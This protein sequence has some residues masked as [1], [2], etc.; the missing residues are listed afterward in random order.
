MVR[1]LG[2]G[3]RVA[4][5]VVDAT[6]AFRSTSSTRQ[7]RPDEAGAAGDEDPFSFEHD[8]ESR[9]ST[10]RAAPWIPGKDPWTEAE[11]APVGFGGARARAGCATRLAP[12]AEPLARAQRAFNDAMLRLTDAL[13]ERVDEPARVPGGRERRGRSSRSGCCGSSVAA[14]KR[15]DG[16]WRL[17]RGRTR[18]RLLR[19]RVAD[20]RA[21][22]RGRASGSGPTWRCSREH[23]P[24]LDVGCG[25]GELLVLLREAGIAARGVD[26]DGDMVAFARGE[27][28]TVEQADALDCTGS[29]GR[30]GRSG[31]SR[32]SSSSSTC[33]RP[34]SSG[35]LELAASAL[36]A[37]RAARA[38]D[39]QSGVTARASQL[40]R[41][42]DARAAARRRRRSSCSCARPAFPTSRCDS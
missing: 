4:M 32:R 23:G 3:E 22:R 5:E 20:A 40:L 24:V 28:S 9:R 27:G 37:R 10:Y 2:A 13:S 18:S 7:R 33:R 11:S 34:C 16:R 38:R 31:R 29:R 30:R 42:P 14:A 41:R 15:G 26:A 12:A 8:G 1:E 6:I 17:S 19:L 39:D 35:L 21:D 36:Q 25:R